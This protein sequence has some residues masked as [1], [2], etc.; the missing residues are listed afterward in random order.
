MLTPFGTIV[1]RRYDTIE[2]EMDKAREEV[3]WLRG[4]SDG[5]LLVGMSP[6]AAGTSIAAIL[7]TFRQ[8]QP[9][10]ELSLLELRPAQI[11]DAVRCGTFDLGIVH[12]YGSFDPAGLQWTALH[13]YPTLLAI[14][15]RGGE[16]PETLDR[17]WSREW[18]T[19]DLVNYTHGY[20]SVLARR[21]GRGV[22]QRISRCTSIS[23][24]FDLSEQSQLVSHWAE[25]AICIWLSS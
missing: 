6:P 14:G 10:V 23:V 25:T 13:S 4:A 9:G 7:A 20:I 2:K 17:L 12:H 5:R 1:S 21:L 24:Y 11:F 22:P 15:G 18:I 3:A 8:R 16:R 19:G